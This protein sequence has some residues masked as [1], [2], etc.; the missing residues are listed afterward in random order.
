MPEQIGTIVSELFY[1]GELRNG[2]VKDT[3][4]FV[5]PDRVIQWINVDGKEELEGTSRKNEKEAKV[6]MEKILE[7]REICRERNLQKEIAVITPYTAQ[8]RLLRRYFTS[9][10][11]ENPKMEELLS[12]KIDTVDAFQGKEADIVFYSTVRSRGNIKFL[13]DTRR[14]NVAISRARENLIFVGN[15]SFFKN[16]K[17]RGEENIF[18]SIL[19]KT[20]MF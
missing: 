7:I 13:L 5:Y 2:L 4:D 14:L 18:L 12:I 16:A 20:E 3:S 17:T 10:L 19:E 1:G 6:L 8:K 9:L 15:K 11:K